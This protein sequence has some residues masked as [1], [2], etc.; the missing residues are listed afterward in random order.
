MRSH[1]GE[2]SLAIDHGADSSVPTILRLRLRR[3]CWRGSSQ[4][5][6]DR[7]DQRWHF[8]RRSGAA[9]HGAPG[10]LGAACGGRD[11]SRGPYRRV[12]F[13]EARQSTFTAER[14]NAP[15]TIGRFGRR[16]ATTDAA[17][18]FVCSGHPRLGAG[19]AA[20]YEKSALSHRKSLVVA[21]I[22]TGVVP[23]PVGNAGTAV[24][25]PT[26]TAVV[27]VAIAPITTGIFRRNVGRETCED[28]Q[29]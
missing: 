2:V 21:F 14:G 3:G 12:R 16:H 11:G 24:I 1:F 25:A 6:A 4:A 29:G 26:G 8:I 5:V 17:S 27:A 20:A 15:D 18:T 7:N 9:W 13:P 19:I 23:A 10:A 22:P 28:S